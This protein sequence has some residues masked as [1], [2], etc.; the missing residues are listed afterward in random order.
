MSS[1]RSVNTEPISRLVHACDQGWYSDI[2]DCAEQVQKAGLNVDADC[3]CRFS[4]R[5][6]F[7]PRARHGGTSRWYCCRFALQ[8]ADFTIFL[9]SFYF[10][11]GP[12]IGISAIVAAVSQCVYLPPCDCILIQLDR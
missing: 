3:S 11:A 8:Q 6:L 12:R 10:M 4:L 2:P 1:R 5:S 9:C 7:D